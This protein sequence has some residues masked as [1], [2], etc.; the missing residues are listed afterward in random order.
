MA[1]PF[2]WF[3]VASAVTGLFGGASAASAARKAAEIQAAATLEAAR[4]QSETQMKI[5]EP[6]LAASRY[7]LPKMMEQTS[8]LGKLLGQDSKFLTSGL[9]QNE[10]SLARSTASAQA[11]TAYRYGQN[12]S[13][14]RGESLRTDLASNNQQANLRLA[15]GTAQEAYRSQNVDRYMSSLQSL[16][17]Q[18]TVGSQLAY[19]AQSTLYGGMA[20]AAQIKG[21]G[22]QDYYSM[23]GGIA[24]KVAGFGL[25]SLQAQQMGLTQGNNARTITGSPKEAS[26]LADIENQTNKWISGSFVDASKAKVKPLTSDDL[27]IKWNI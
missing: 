12:T 15:Y 26:I 4:M 7:A 18:G 2:P 1:T 27:K 24:G 17:G 11:S 16:A 23:I 21:Q 25:G 10:A 19:G 14:S 5:A 20:N 6:M 22:A 8:A 9:K 3:E 13:R